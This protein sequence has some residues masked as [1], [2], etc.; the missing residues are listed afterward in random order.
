MHKCPTR[1]NPVQQLD[2]RILYAGE[3]HIGAEYAPVPT[4][5]K[6]SHG[7]LRLT[8]P[9]SS[10][11]RSSSPTLPLIDSYPPHPHPPDAEISL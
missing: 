4:H 9:T 11:P 6:T 3:G 1:I 8:L 10:P 7:N 5:K 2:S